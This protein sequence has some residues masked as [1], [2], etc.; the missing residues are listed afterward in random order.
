[1]VVICVDRSGRGKKIQPRNWEWVIAIECMSNDGFVLFL[2]LVVQNVNHFVSW[3]IEYNLFF[4][5]VIK[6]FPNGWTDNDIALQ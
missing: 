6:T 5:W 1:M 2:F 3:Y 4:S